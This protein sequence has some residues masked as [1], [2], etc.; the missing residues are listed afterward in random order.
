MLGLPMNPFFIQLLVI[1]RFS[2]TC[3]TNL[4]YSDWSSHPA[5]AL[6]NKNHVELFKKQT[7]FKGD[8]GNFMP[9]FAR[10]FNDKSSPVVELIEKELRK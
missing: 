3:K 9:F 10:K 5:P 8:Y 6:I 1:H 7:E 2:V 4:T